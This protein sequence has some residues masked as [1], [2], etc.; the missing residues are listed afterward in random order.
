[1]NWLQRLA[2]YEDSREVLD[3]EYFID[4]SGF[5]MNADGETGTST[6]VFLIA[7]ARRKSWQ[8]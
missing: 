2:Q 6:C 4:N 5:S 1:M 3:G 7:V 8:R